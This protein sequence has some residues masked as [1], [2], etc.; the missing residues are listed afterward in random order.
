MAGGFHFFGTTGF[1]SS[2]TP[3]PDGNLWFTES[4]AQ[5]PP[6]IGKISAAGIVTEFPLPADLHAVGAIASGPNDALWFTD[7]TDDKIGRITTS[8]AVTEYALPASTAPEK[9]TAGGDGNLWFTDGSGIGRIT[10]GGTFTEFPV[11]G[12]SPS[13]I[14]AGPDGNVWFTQEN[15]YGGGP[16]LVGRIGRITPAGVISLFPLPEAPP[17][18]YAVDGSQPEQ[19]T[20][21]PDG[22]LWYTDSLDGGVG[23]VTP[24]GAITEFFGGLSGSPYA[25]T[26]GPDGNLWITTLGLETVSRVTP[27][28]S[29]TSFLLPGASTT[30]FSQNPLQPLSI[31]TGPDGNIWFTEAPLNAVGQRGQIGQLI[32]K[33]AINSTGETIRPTAHT[34]FSGVVATFTSGSPVASTAD[35]S[36]TIAWGDGQTSTGIVSPGA[37]GTFTVTG[38]HSYA[39][40]VAFSVLVT[41][42]TP[43]DSSTVTGTAIVA[44][45]PMV[46]TIQAPQESHHGFDRVFVAFTTALDPNT[47]R[48]LPNYTLDLL[49][50]EGR[51]RPLK[52]LRI[53]LAAAG[54]APETRIVTLIPTRPLRP[55]AAYR[56][57]INGTSGPLP[58]SDS[59]GARLDGAGNGLPGS[60]SMTTFVVPRRVKERCSGRPE[61]R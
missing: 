7:P 43:G 44:A 31:T 1:P 25:I 4:V 15:G 18:A 22:N 13:G 24:A 41:I 8:G 10:T 37:G 47:A 33:D 46:A 3:G 52:A 60:D 29:V 48:F 23:R 19:I 45:P 58:V 9:I 30:R 16:G 53:R 21:G 55:G 49:V 56:L 36:A 59:N 11:A 39:M 32:L 26:A 6:L 5:S 61:R 34:P 51:H 57:T 17:S 54:Y 28:G 12:D 42:A 38:T 27:S 2:L 35:F 14:T 40:P 20:T 50:W